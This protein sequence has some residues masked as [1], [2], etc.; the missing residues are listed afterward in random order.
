M[1][2]D[3]GSQNFGGETMQ[4]KPADLILVKGTDWISDTIKDVEK[5]PYSHL[6]G[7][8]KDS[9]L[10]E[11]QGFKR[12]GYQA[13]GNYTGSADVFTCDIATDEQRREM[14]SRIIQACGKPL[15]AFPFALGIYPVRD[16]DSS[17]Y[18]PGPNRICST[19]WIEDAYRAVGIDLCPGIKYP[20]P[21]DVAQSR[22]LR[23]VGSF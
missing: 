4:I 22:L 23:K 7:L 2:K 9:E 15:L 16:W 6:A 11:A 17:P 5:S 1:S 8:V 20:S 12:T 10:I 18:D 19:L 14:V 3:K 21:A 13:L